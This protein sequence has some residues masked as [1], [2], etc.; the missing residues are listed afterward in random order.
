[1]VVAA[2]SD[3][4]LQSSKRRALLQKGSAARLA[5][6]ARTALF[7]SLKGDDQKYAATQVS[8]IMPSCPPL[9][10]TPTSRNPKTADDESSTDP[11]VDVIVRQADATCE[12]S[13]V[14]PWKPT[15]SLQLPWPEG[16]L[17]GLEPTWT[18][19][20]AGGNDGAARSSPKVKWTLP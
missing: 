8:E 2:D 11:I 19:D 4:S 13:R 17:Q 3:A 10:E 9:S 6:T 18:R 15:F 14:T 20:K 1:M 5:P 16:V 7:F 12:P